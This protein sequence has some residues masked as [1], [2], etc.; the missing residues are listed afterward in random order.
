MGIIQVVGLENRKLN[1]SNINIINSTVPTKRSQIS[2]YILC[3]ALPQVGGETKH[4]G[5]NEK[6]KCD[7]CGVICLCKTRQR[8]LVYALRPYLIQSKGTCD[9]VAYRNASSCTNTIWCQ[10]E[11]HLGDNF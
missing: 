9:I 4:Q 1:K 7:P 2:T 8:I 6:I 10:S 11:V 3:C 5:D